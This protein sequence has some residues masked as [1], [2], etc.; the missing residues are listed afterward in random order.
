MPPVLN[1]CTELP[2]GQM[3]QKESIDVMHEGHVLPLC[4]CLELCQ[5]E[6]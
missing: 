5:Q 4:Q 6:Q 3:F 1:H 2:L